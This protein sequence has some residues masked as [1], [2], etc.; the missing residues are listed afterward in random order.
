MSE[1]LGKYWKAKE[2]RESGEDK[3]EFN[4]QLA[5]CECRMHVLLI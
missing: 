3:R 2:R 1:L 4:Q 5:Q